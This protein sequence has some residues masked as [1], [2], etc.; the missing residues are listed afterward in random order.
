MVNA[1][2]DGGRAS[3]DTEWRIAS[4]TA[5]ITWPAALA[6]E[7]HQ[8][9]PQC[10]YACKTVAIR[11]FLSVVVCLRHNAHVTA[12]GWFMTRLSQFC[13]QISCR[14]RGT[15]P[16]ARTFA[17]DSL[18]LV[19]RKLPGVGSFGNILLPRFKGNGDVLLPGLKRDWNIL[20][21][22]VI[23]VW[24]CFGRCVGR[25]RDIR[26]FRCCQHPSWGGLW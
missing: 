11:A 8:N 1:A 23:I 24:R 3:T 9:Y 16:Q 15:R 26:R 13:S 20:V 7:F 19:G 5:S 10:Q 22:T 14:F 2:V 25:C 6:R 17:N 12:Q 21:P 4:H 18:I